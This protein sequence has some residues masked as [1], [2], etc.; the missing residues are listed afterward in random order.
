M[1]V[2]TKRELLASGFVLVYSVTSPFGVHS[3]MLGKCLGL[4]DTETP[5]RG[6]AF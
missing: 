2:L 3:V 4:S 1:T 6:K 5:R